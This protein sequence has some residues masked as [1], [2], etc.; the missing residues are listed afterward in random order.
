MSIFKNVTS[1]NTVKGEADRIGGSRILDSNLYSMKVTLAYALVAASGAIGLVVGLKSDSGQEIRET[2]WTTSGK[3]KGGKNFY[4]KDGEKFYLPGFLAA[5]G[6]CLL[7][8]G[9][10]LSELDTEEKL[11]KLYDYEAK[12]EIPTKVNMVVD[13]LGQEV[14]VG[15]LKTLVDKT[16][17]DGNNVYQPTGETRE[18]NTID[19]FFRARD[20]MT[21][22]EIRAQAEKAVFADQWAEKFAG[23]VINKAK[24]ASGKA[25]APTKA[26]SNDAA[27]EPR[28]SL[29]A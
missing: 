17:K 18:A 19:K 9:K 5:N 24:G 23:Q 28:K 26:A 29:F 4:E 21:V 25:G 13:L 16:A 14:L 1:D 3:D 15:V 20:R 8:V 27:K 6:L 7:T 12:A 22:A 10:E 11:V 2:L